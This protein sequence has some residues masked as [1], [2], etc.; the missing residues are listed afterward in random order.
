MLFVKSSNLN[1]WG[2]ENTKEI[3][4]I[5]EI[6]KRNDNRERSQVGAQSLK[7]QQNLHHVFEGFLKKSPL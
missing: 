7:R 3:I 2:L 4:N 6:E 5:L 1:L